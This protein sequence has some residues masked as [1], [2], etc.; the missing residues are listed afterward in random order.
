MR[1]TDQLIYIGDV[2]RIT[3]SAAFN[4]TA[5]CQSDGHSVGVSQMIGLLSFGSSLLAVLAEFQHWRLATF[6]Q[7]YGWVE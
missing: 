6:R 3:Q 1:H 4:S 5:C 2:V 7:I